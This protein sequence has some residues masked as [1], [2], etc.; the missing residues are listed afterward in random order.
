MSK[1][2]DADKIKAFL[3]PDEWK[4]P[5]ERW[6]PESEFGA[7]VDAIPTADVEPVRR[8]KDCNNFRNN[9]RVTYCN[10]FAATIEKDDFCSYFISKDGRDGYDLQS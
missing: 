1:Y 6:L 5:D 9:G 8:C 10:F 2:I 3:R 4:T 7:I